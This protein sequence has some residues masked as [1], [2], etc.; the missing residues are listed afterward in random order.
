[1]PMPRWW[2]RINNAVFNPME[3]R[4]GKRPVLHHVGRASGKPYQ[5]PLDAVPVDGGYMFVLVYGAKSDWVRNALAAGRARLSV[6]GSDVELV[7]PR[8]VGPDVA[9]PLLPAKKHPP[10][11]LKI[12]EFLMMD[13]AA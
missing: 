1:M 6:D 10:K 11:L 12:D 13:V 3:L 2:P 4:R 5:T 8:V 7:N 9:L